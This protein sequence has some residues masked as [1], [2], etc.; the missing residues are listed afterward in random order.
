M[1]IK[2]QGPEAEVKI[3]WKVA[4]VKPHYKKDKLL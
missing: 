4:H 1:D 3:K 2:T